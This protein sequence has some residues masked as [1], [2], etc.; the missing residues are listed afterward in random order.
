MLNYPNAVRNKNSE[1]RC[2]IDIFRVRQAGH[3]EAGA[4]VLVVN[5][6]T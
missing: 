4:Y 2:R 5:P 3:F 1:Y 6:T